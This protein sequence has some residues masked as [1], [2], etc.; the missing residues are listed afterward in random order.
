MNSL[1]RRQILRFSLAAPLL[2]V[3][4]QSRAATLSAPT[5]KPI[6]EISGKIHVFN[7]GETARFDIAML[8]GLG[9]TSFKT[10]T[11]WYSG[12]VTFEGVPMATLLDAV[13]A[14][15]DHIVVTALN[16]YTSEIPI[17]D[18]QEFGVLL[19]L[20]RDGAYMPVRDKGPLFIVYPYDS[21]PE[22]RQQKYY[23]RSA[24]QVAKI[25]V[26]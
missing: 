1:D 14:F 9:M 2:G 13:G 11:P 3:A 17:S 10:V 5:G 6:L 21:R 7:D 24:W 25:V 23:S 19:A 20:K 18:F 16:D 4:V 26:K 12:P 15:G 22:L 8:E